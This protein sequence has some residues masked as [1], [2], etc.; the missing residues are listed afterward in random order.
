[1]RTS[2][3]VRQTDRAEG[4]LRQLEIVFY[5]LE[6]LGTVFLEEAPHKIFGSVGTVQPII[7]N[8]SIQ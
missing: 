8:A 2:R 4:L 3:H 6:V 1:M 7:M 5:T